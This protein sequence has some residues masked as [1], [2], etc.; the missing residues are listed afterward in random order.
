MRL[1]SQTKNV[2]GLH[3]AVSFVLELL[4][5][6]DDVTCVLLLI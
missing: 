3:E 6:V 1:L 4:Q 2:R 5:N